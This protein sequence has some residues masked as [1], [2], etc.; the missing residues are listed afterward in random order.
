MARQVE[1]FQKRLEAIGAD[2]DSR[3]PSTPVRILPVT[4]RLPLTAAPGLA[5]QGDAYGH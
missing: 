4:V 5:G 3:L 1:R 2:S